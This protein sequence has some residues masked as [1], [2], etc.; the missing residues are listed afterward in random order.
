M[1]KLTLIT[2]TLIF[3]VGCEKD[4]I[5]YVIIDDPTL[6]SELYSNS[7]DTLQIGASRY[8]LDTYLY[9]DYFPGVPTPKNPKHPLIASIVLRNLDSLTIPNTISIKKLYVI[10][11]QLIWPSN[12]ID[13][14]QQVF[15]YQLKRVS[16]SGPEWGPENDA[17]VVV[18]IIDSSINKEYYLIAKNQEIFITN[19]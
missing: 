4:K 9:R 17:D 6:L 7:S 18:K 10:Y 3:T 19:K 13:T 14:K 8:I 15:P 2:L 12:P 5:P 1:Y 16:A 11:N